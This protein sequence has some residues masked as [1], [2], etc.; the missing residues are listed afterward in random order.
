MTREKMHYLWVFVT[1]LV[2]LLLS[3]S[4]TFASKSQQS[5]DEVF[6]GVIRS[7]IPR[8]SN[9]HRPNGSKPLRHEPTELSPIEREFESLSENTSQS[10]LEVP[11]LE[12]E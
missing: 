12:L 9:I 11:D 3:A 8:S 6:R 5:T 2:G 1:G 10:Q 7:K 4:T